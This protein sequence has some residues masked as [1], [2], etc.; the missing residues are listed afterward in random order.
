MVRKIPGTVVSESSIDT[1]DS[2]TLDIVGKLPST[3][4]RKLSE[5][6]VDSD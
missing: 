5:E 3:V 4:V 2:D 1:V 6:A